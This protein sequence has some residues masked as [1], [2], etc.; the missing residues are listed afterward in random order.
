[1]DEMRRE[2]VLYIELVLSYVGGRV[3]IVYY[4][5]V[6][7]NLPFFVWWTVGIRGG[8]WLDA[9]EPLPSPPL[10]H[11]NILLVRKSEYKKKGIIY[12]INIINSN[13]M[14]KVWTGSLSPVYCYVC[15]Y[16]Y[17]EGRVR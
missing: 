2:S 16:I 11:H 8:G 7:G 12:I 17:M 13:K 3:S 10:F 14:P 6:F 15:V 5:F 4:L 1:M 9:T